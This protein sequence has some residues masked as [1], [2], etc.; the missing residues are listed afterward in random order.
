MP[1]TNFR[2]Y[3]LDAVPY[4]CLN[5]LSQKTAAVHTFAQKGSSSDGQ[6]SQGLK[7]IE[8]YERHT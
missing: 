1:F 2:S 6:A 5:S 3:M 4:A 8:D 7:F